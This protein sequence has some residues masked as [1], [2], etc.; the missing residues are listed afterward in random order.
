MAPVNPLDPLRGPLL[1]FKDDPLGTLVRGAT[2]GASGPPKT[3]TKTTFALRLHAR[4]GNRSGVIGSV[5]ELSPNQVIQVDDEFEVDSLA[6]GVP[7][8][9]VPQALTSRTLQIARY[10]TYVATMEQIF[11]SQSVLGGGPELLTLT[12]QRTPI[13]ML[14]YWT[15]PLV[16]DIDFVVE[17]QKQLNIYQFCDCYITN[18]GRRLS[19]KDD[20]VVRADA[21]MTWRTIR[22]LQ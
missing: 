9:L 21:T 1:G 10:D 4:V 14:M 12:D 22:R 18:L 15:S 5:F 13:S 17:S 7:R 2:V 19:A 20:V 8:E 16:S 6:E 3:K 11:G